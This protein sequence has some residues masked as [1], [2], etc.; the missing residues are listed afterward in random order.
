MLFSLD[1]NISSSEVFGEPL[2]VS[3]IM[4]MLFIFSIMEIRRLK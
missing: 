3:S 1:K 4:K 2:F